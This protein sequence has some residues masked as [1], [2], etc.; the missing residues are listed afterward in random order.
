MSIPGAWLTD[1]GDNT[2]NLHSN[3]GLEYGDPDYFGASILPEVSP[4]GP[5]SAVLTGGG[6]TLTPGHMWYEV[7]L[8]DVIDPS[9]VLTSPTAF[10]EACSPQYEHVVEV[11]IQMEVSEPFY[12]GFWIDDWDLTGV[13]KPGDV[14]G[15]AQLVYDGTTLHLLDSAAENAAPGIVAGRYQSVPEP[16]VL[17]LLVLGAGGITVLRRWRQFS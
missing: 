1:F 16:S 10:M 6:Y 13:P 17:I 5:M 3:N 4:D 15:W 12:V 2:Y 8:D 11:P 9:F 14:F 7:S